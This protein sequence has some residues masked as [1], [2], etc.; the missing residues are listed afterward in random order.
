VRVKLPRA[1]TGRRG[2]DAAAA[3]PRRDQGSS[4]SSSSSSSSATARRAEELES[5]VR[6]AAVPRAL[7]A[8]HLGM[9]WAGRSSA[10]AAAAGAA[11]HNP[12]PGGGGGGGGDDGLPPADSGSPSGRGSGGRGFGGGLESPPTSPPR[13]ALLDS[14]PPGAYKELRG[15]PGGGS[16]GPSRRPAERRRGAVRV[17]VVGRGQDAL[18]AKTPLLNLPLTASVLAGAPVLRRLGLRATPLL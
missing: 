9:A 10:P 1:L 15:G 8:K 4:S 14:P 13:N 7:H 12:A 2:A 6:A 5:R 3:A 18:A 17:V 11:S 16:L